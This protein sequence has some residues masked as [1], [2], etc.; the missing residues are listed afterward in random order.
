MASRMPTKILIYLLRHDLRFSDNPV[1]HEIQESFQSGTAAF[2]H[3]LPLYVFRSHQIEISGFIPAAKDE[4]SMP[5]SPYPEARSQVAGFW[6]C[7]PHRAKFL[8]ESVWDL[9]NTL[10]Q[11][12]SGL[13]IRVGRV[14][15]V[16]RDIFN[17]VDNADSSSGK[18]S[19]SSADLQVVGVWMTKDEG[20]EEKQEEAEVRSLVESSGRE[21]RA[22][23]DEKYYVNDSDLPFTKIEDLPDVFTTFRKS[24]EPLRARARLPLLD[25]AKLPPLPQE[26][27][28][29]RQIRPFEIPTNLPD[30]ISCLLRPIDIDKDFPNPPSWPGDTQSAHPF[31]GGESEAHRRVDYLLS[32]GAMTAYKETRNGLLGPDFSTKL[33]AYLALGCISAR[34]VSAEMALFED[35]EIRNDR[36]GGTREEKLAKLERWKQAAGFG[37]GE[38]EG[39][40]GV[41]FELLWRDYFRLVERKYG[42]K[43]FAIQGL[44]GG[45]SKDWQYMRGLAEEEV[46]AKLRRFCTG[47]TGL[48]LIDAAQRELYL[49]G[50]T[51]NRARQNVASFLAKHLNIDWRLGAEWYE[52]MLVDYDVANNWGNWQYVAGV[53]NDP[54][55]GRLFNPVKQALDY[56]PRG[57]YIKAWV[58]EL[59]DVDLGAEKEGA[60]HDEEKLMGLFQPWRLAPEEKQK[61]GLREL[62]FVDKP[63]VQIQFSVGRKPRAP[64]RNRGR[65]FRGRGGERGGG[66]K[67]S[68]SGPRGSGR[69]GRGRG[70][71]RGENQA[72]AETEKQDSHEG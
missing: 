24:I 43:L 69:G 3:L 14:T 19:A 25:V 61:L 66:G 34:Q 12:H 63:L 23:D 57:E 38:N 59:R 17:H 72:P 7:G 40:A 20:Y 48:G 58:K 1:F 70:R 30:L 62:D 36:W 16:L 42:A 51:S 13:V 60:K 56:D 35:G 45:K 18:K 29:P 32:S 27:C 28:I 64:G 52:C 31:H 49:T 33:S 47:R 46:R 67:A 37:K 9:K 11:K 68:L 26:T 41:R 10:E 39:T 65:G 53:G 71:W 5:K 6:R 2:T 8:A 21:Y 50:Y 54:R 22:F 55:E 44:R 4:E 15:D